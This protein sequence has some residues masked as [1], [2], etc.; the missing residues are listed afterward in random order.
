MKEIKSNLKTFQA[1]R[2]LSNAEAF[3]RIVR[4]KP[5]ESNLSLITGVNCLA[6]QGCN[7][8]HFMLHVGSVATS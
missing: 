8:R 7:T 4:I 6:D 5:A 1:A 3:S 2:R